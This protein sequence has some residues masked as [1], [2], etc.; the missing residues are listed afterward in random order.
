MKRKQRIKSLL[1][2]NFKEFTFEILDNSHLHA[3]HN[4][5]DGLN[6]THIQILLKNKTPHKANRLNIHRKIRRK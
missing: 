1:L 5:F 6:E 2:E 3:G 4:N